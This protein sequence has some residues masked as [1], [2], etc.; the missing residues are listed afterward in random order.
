MA[1]LMDVANGLDGQMA[2]VL[3]SR[4][5]P[6]VTSAAAARLFG[7]RDHMHAKRSGKLEPLERLR[8]LKTTCMQR[9]SRLQSPDQVLLRRRDRFVSRCNPIVWGLARTMCELRL[10][11][12]VEGRVRLPEQGTPTTR[13]S[14]SM[15]RL[16]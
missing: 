3:S 12:S 6:G 15:L 4:A 10:Q 14:A 7:R 5:F 13:S 16:L 8:E 1:G 2:S 11:E 9:S